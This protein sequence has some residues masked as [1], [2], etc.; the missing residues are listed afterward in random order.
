MMRFTLL[1]LLF[2]SGIEVR[3]KKGW[4]D[5]IELNELSGIGCMILKGGLGVYGLTLIKYETNQV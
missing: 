4:F 3:C 5:R 1:F 2:C